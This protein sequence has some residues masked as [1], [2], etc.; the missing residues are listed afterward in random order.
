[1][2]AWINAQMLDRLQ[3]FK[4]KLVNMAE[5]GLKVEM[6]RSSN[7]NSTMFELRMF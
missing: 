5:M 2:T 4:T 3:D 1:M 6:R 7:L